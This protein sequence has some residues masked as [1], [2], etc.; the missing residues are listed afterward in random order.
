MVRCPMSLHC[1]EC[2]TKLGLRVVNLDLAVEAPQAA[3][4][5]PQPRDEAP[6]AP[7]GG[8][9]A[10]R[11]KARFQYL[12][13]KFLE[14]WN[15]YPR[16]VGKASAL[17]KWVT[18]TRE[19]NPDVIIAAAQRYAAQ[20][21]AQRI[22]PQFVKYP[23]GWLAGGHWDDEELVTLVGET[24]PAYILGTPEYAAR[25]QAEEDAAIEAM[26]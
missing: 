4:E 12:D 7:V 6:Q 5:A 25:M 9:R 16:H 22:D 11:P 17:K 3:V 15:V 20:V 21:R 14:F 2:G 23:E 24:N 1:P 19:I 26:S 13:E 8:E 18:A 10:S